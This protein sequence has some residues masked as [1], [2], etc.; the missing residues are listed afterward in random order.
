MKHICMPDKSV[1]PQATAAV[2]RAQKAG[3]LQQRLQ[4]NMQSADEKCL[5][6][7]S[8]C[9]SDR[10]DCPQATAAVTRAQKAGILQQRLQLNMQSAS[11]GTGQ[12]SGLSTVQQHAHAQA[13]VASFVELM[14]KQL[15]QQQAFQVMFVA[16][17]MLLPN[18]MHVLD[19]VS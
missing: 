10:C 8:N 7:T 14:L 19:A 12:D 13:A 1:C 17:C 6:K 16:D 11:A 3:I 15:Q 5:N 9:M 4:L 18:S 2:A